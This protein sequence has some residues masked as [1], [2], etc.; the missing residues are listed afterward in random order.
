MNSNGN[1]EVTRAL[2]YVTEEIKM[3][4]REALQRANQ[5]YMEWGRSHPMYDN[6]NA[7]SKAD[8][9]RACIL[10][11]LEEACQIAE[12]DIDWRM[13]R[14]MC[15]ITIGQEVL[16]RLVKQ[17]N[18]GL[19]AKRSKILQHAEAT[20]LRQ[21]EF[22]QRALPWVEEEMQEKPDLSVYEYQL[23]AAYQVDIAY[24]V[25]EV[26]FKVENGLTVI[27]SDEL[28]GLPGQK[29]PLPTHFQADNYE[30]APKTTFVWREAGEDYEH[31][32]SAAPVQQKSELH[33]PSVH[34][35][36]EGGEQPDETENPHDIDEHRNDQETTEF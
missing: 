25:N 22:C 21:N 27:K 35:R 30:A 26:T 8:F 1:D 9:M 36:M 28:G 13:E 24:E 18:P 12:C 34:S 19:P 20:R 10:P 16:M 33:D 11:R 3:V 32:G 6:L 15:L 23:T 4:I 14:G 5:D 7:K 29:Q 31:E 17:Q 2:E